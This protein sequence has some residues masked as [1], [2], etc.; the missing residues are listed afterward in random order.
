MSEAHRA[1][2]GYV[3]GMPPRRVGLLLL[4]VALGLL[5]LWAIRAQ[6][7]PGASAVDEVTRPANVGGGPPPPPPSAPTPDGPN[8]V[9]I[10]IRQLVA[11]AQAAAA[12]PSSA[13]SPNSAATPGLTDRRDHPPR[14]AAEE[15][16][17]VEALLHDVDAAS[18]ACVR[19]LRVA[20][21]TR[22]G[23]VKVA[24]QID[25]DGLTDAWVTEPIDVPAATLEC[26]AAAVEAEDWADLVESPAEISRVYAL[27]E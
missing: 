7:A 6:V 18:E 27:V 1:Q 10:P 19:A 14:D 16:A 24:F 4:A 22:T 17:A 11:L 23:D 26:L 13:P 21:P 9:R 15:R 20:E 2:L 5:A 25:I 12:S 3:E 8:R